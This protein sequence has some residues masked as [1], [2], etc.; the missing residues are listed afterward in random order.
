MEGKEF[1][2]FAAV[3]RN[4]NQTF[5]WRIPKHATI[6]TAEAMA[7]IETLRIIVSSVNESFT[8]FSDSKS[9]LEAMDAPPKLGGSHLI[10]LIK[11]LLKTMSDKGKKVQFYW[12]PAHKGIEYNEIVDIKAKE[13]A[14]SG[15]DTQILAPSSDWKTVWKKNNRRNSMTGVW[16]LLTK[17]GK[18]ISSHV[19]SNVGTHGLQ[20]SK[21]A[22]ELY[23]PSID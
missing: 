18:N 13:S 12:I 15:R 8:V 1:V 3:R 2:G 14:V 4:D 21:Y 17:K 5:A 22:E 16:K 7:I 10:L 9:V 23:H 6:F 11:D 19:T 20:I